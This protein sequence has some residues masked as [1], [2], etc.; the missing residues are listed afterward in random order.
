MGAARLN[1]KRA[2]HALV[3]MVLATAC[4]PAATPLPTSVPEIPEKDKEDIRPSRDARPSYSPLLLPKDA[5]ERGITTCGDAKLRRIQPK[6][7]EMNCGGLL[8]HAD[9]QIYI[10][11]CRAR[12]L[13]RPGATVV[14]GVFEH[15]TRILDL[16]DRKRDSIRVI[17]GKNHI[18]LNLG[19]ELAI[20]SSSAPHPEEDALEDVIRFRDVQ[21]LRVSSEYKVVLFEYSLADTL[22]YCLIFKQLSESPEMQDK[23]LLDEILKATV[24]LNTI[25]R[26]SREPYS[27][28]QTEAIA[29]S[30][31][32]RRFAAKHDGSAL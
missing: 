26:H 6:R 14:I 32:N 10:Q 9:E 12:I 27:H 28:G 17:F 29:A 16:G 7:Y 13:L 30:K 24:S 4:A 20:V 3:S 2:T 21:T 8:V 5:A 15:V 23:R 1:T 25:Y 11:T 31:R 18:S 19:E 22:K